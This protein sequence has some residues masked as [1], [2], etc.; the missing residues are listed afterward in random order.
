V[1]LLL[2]Y[3]LF[4]AKLILIYIDPP[5][6]SKAD[7]RTKIKFARMIFKK[8]RRYIE[9]YAYADTWQD[10]TVSYLKMI[11]PRLVLMREL[12]SDK[13]VFMCILIGMLMLM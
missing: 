5:F 8:N 2:D 3:L 6:D 9:Q 13:V 10:G 12:L 11:Y 7:Y 4:A 1:I